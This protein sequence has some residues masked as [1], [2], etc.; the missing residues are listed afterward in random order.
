MFKVILFVS[1]FCLLNA[2]TIQGT[3]SYAGNSKTPKTVKMD[4]DPICGAAHTVPP[5]KQD[6]ILNE[7][8]KF[9]N[10]IVWLK[11]TEENI[12]NYEGV[13]EKNDFNNGA[14][15]WFRDFTKIKRQNYSE[16]VDMSF[17]NNAK[18]L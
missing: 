15:V 7:N 13:V 4:S 8:N 17:I 5:T 16:V 11:P 10:V 9:K 12:F 6:F 3:V 14:K 18:K 1:T 2:T